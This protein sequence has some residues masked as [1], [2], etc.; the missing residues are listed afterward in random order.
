VLV[1]VVARARRPPAACACVHSGWKGA[2]SSI[3]AAAF[4][5]ACFA[6]PQPMQYSHRAATGQPQCSHR[7]AATRHP[8]KPRAPPCH[9]PLPNPLVRPPPPGAPRGPTLPDPPAA[10]RIVKALHKGRKAHRSCERTRGAR[11]PPRRVPRRPSAGHTRSRVRAS[12]TTR[13]KGRRDGGLGRAPAPRSHRCKRTMAVSTAHEE[14]SC[15]ADMVALDGVGPSRTA[16]LR[17]TC[18][19]KI[20]GQGCG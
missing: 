8:A 10:R 15:R 14:G 1:L 20:G 19:C 3:F 18:L 17:V 5:P 9:A 7:R 4:K 2:P 11:R 13:R 12:G 16:A 6:S